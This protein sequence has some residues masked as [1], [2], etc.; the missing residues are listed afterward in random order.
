MSFPQDQVPTPTTPVSIRLPSL[1]LER[2]DADVAS[3]NKGHA[4]SPETRSDRIIYLLEYAYQAGALNQLV[5]LMKA[6]YLEILA[7]TPEQLAAGAASHN[8]VSNLADRVND[9][10]DK[11]ADVLAILTKL[12]AQ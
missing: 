1:L 2:I 5:D 6:Q 3:W 9:I 12:S 11:L 8:Q 10:D 4:K 7:V